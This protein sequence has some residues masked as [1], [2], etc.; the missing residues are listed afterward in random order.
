M[1]WSRPCRPYRPCALHQ[2]RIHRPSRY[3]S[4][5]SIEAGIMDQP[6]EEPARLVPA[7]DVERRYAIE[8]TRMT[9]EAGWPKA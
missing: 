1:V 2:L 7:E 8:Q 5:R 6:S 4:A 3:R 9:L